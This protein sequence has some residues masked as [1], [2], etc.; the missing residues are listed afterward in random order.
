MEVRRFAA[1]LTDR[2]AGASTLHAAIKVARLVFGIAADAGAIRANPASQ[3]RL[4]RPA[5]TEML[6]LTPEQVE[7]LARAITPGYASLVRFAAYTGLRAGEIGAL[8]VGR[9]DLLRG[10]V[11]VAESLAEVNGRLIF[12]ATKTYAKRFVPLPAFLRDELGAHLAG[13]SRDPEALVFTA[14]QGGALRH[15]L[16][17]R[18]HYKPAVAAVGLPAT[19]RFHDLRHT[20]AAFC[21]ASTA[22]PYAV[23]KRMG[24][25]SIT[26]TYNTYGHLFPERD[27]EITRGLEDLFRRAGVDF[28]WTPPDQSAEVRRLK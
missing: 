17:Y 14:P 4:A 15:N 11:E 28:S 12:G 10:Q 5:R 27:Q 21:I 19:L 6:F 2:G 24:H 3:L 8:R 25:S 16:F 18:R 23:M 22:D 20:Y 7:W 13:R 26:V 1:A 9:L